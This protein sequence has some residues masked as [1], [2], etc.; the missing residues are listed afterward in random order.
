MRSVLRRCYCGAGGD[1]PERHRDQE[2]EVQEWKPSRKSVEVKIGVRR[3][4]NDVSVRLERCH[5]RS[6]E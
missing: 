2:Y 6:W 5:N 3:L 1:K 4:V